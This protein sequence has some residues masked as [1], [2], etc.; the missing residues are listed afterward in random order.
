MNV[1]AFQPTVLTS[2]INRSSSNFRVTTL[3]LGKDG[4]VNHSNTESEESVTKDKKRARVMKFL[5]KVG[6][7]GANQ[8]FSTVSFIDELPL[9]G[10]ILITL[11]SRKITHLLPLLDHCAR[12]WV[13]MKALL[14]R[15]KVLL[16]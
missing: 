15:I 13:L 10:K 6:A 14:G 2:S 9:N 12:L 11:Y 8:D 3:F 7:V 5:R 16:W 1:S 4:K